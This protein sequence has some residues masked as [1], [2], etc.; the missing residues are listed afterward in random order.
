MLQKFDNYRQRKAIE[1]TLPGP[2]YDDFLQAFIVTKFDT[3]FYVDLDGNFCTEFRKIKWPQRVQKLQLARPYLVA[4]LANNQW[5][6]RCILNPLSII[7]DHKLVPCI[8]QTCCV[9]ANIIAKN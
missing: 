5:Q 3:S 9:S 4:L 8:Y 6:V 7:Q 2:I 1:Q